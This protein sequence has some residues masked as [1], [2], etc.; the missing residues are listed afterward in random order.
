MTGPE[1]AKP[2]PEQQIEEITALLRE[3]KRLPPQLFPHLFETSKEYQ[4]GYAGKAR[5]ADVLADTMAVPLQPVRTFGPSDA[6]SNMLVLGDNL[7]VLRRLVEMKQAGDL[8]NADGTDG[9]RLCYI[10]P[11]F[12]TRREFQGTKGER[13]YMDRVEGAEF[14]EFLRRRLILIHEVLS[15]DGSIY[16]HLD[17][18]KSH[19]I[20]VILDEVFGE[21]NFRRE[22]VWDTQVLSGFK[23]QA[24]N[25]IRG[26][27]TILYYTKSA[28]FVFNK[29]TVPH[30]QE[31][32][33]RFDEVEEETG[34]QY[35]GGR[36]P[37]RYLDEVIAKGK[38]VGD[39]WDDIMS[40]QQMPT[41]LEKTGYPTQKPEELL[42]RIVRASSNPGDV[43]L[44]CFV[45]SG[46]TLVA[47][48]TCSDGPR[49]WIGVD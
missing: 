27:D 23:T 9:V 19:Y 10:D 35:F 22:I 1:G 20:K 46:T 39:V 30:R 45:G 13:A 16:V 33:D 11:P 38:A 15:D 8:R 12:A 24:K 44:D 21:Q 14:V 6:W 2:L 4:L 47:A 43:V 49:R 40:F 31:Y 25:W 32:L 42:R 5:R 36:G 18:K 34:R 7:Q 37:R 26:H 48:E 29:I 17:E 3:G 28:N 41:S